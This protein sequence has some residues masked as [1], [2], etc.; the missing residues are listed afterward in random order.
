MCIRGFNILIVGCKVLTNTLNPAHRVR[1]G[2]NL[3]LPQWSAPLAHFCKEN[4][5]IRETFLITYNAGYT[6]SCFMVNIY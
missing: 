5:Q 4:E 2:E 1:I 3:M 6:T